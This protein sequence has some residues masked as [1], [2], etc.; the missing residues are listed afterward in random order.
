VIADCSAS[1]ELEPD[2]AGAWFLRGKAL[3]KTGEHARSVA[4]FRETTARKPDHLDAYLWRGNACL[5]LRDY[6]GALAS[7][8]E[9]LRRKPDSA[10]FLLNRSLAHKGKQNYAQALADLHAALAIDP[11]YPNGNNNLAWLLATCAD[12]SIRD[13]VKALEYA[14]KA[15]D[16]TA[17][18]NPLMLGTLGA[19][20]GELGQFDEGI[21]WIKQALAHENLAA[22]RAA[23]ITANLKCLEQGQ[24]IRD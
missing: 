19:T 5:R 22:S 10:F 3:H 16:L 11:Q 21:R 17:W 13:G 6:D 12:A 7:Y 8:E 9:G 20:Y 14:R 18:N 2:D 23:E 15:C 4:D 24:P 1:L